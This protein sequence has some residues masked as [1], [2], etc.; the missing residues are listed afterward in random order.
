MEAEHSLEA[1]VPDV[2]YEAEVGGVGIVFQD[3][4]GA[5][6]AVLEPDGTPVYAGYHAFAVPVGTLAV[7]VAQM[8]AHLSPLGVEVLCRNNIIPIEV[9]IAGTD[10]LA[11]LYIITP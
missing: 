9:T 2:G 10:V 7:L 11:T 3:E 4:F 5:E 1:V 6:P 8:A